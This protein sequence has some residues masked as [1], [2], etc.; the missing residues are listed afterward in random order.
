M[1]DVSSGTAASL[2]QRAIEPGIGRI[3]LPKPLASFIGRERELAQARQLLQG[4]Y[5]VTLT[6]P[7]GS[8]KTRLCIALA[9][10]VAGDYPD[11]VYFVPLAPVQD[12]GLVPSTIAQS[13]GLQDARDR[14]LMEHLVSQLR[15][16]QLLIVLD[17]FEHLLAGA[18]VVTR[19]LQ[20]TTALRI[21]VSSRSSLRVS[22]EQECPIPPLPVPDPEIRPT[23]A[24]LADCES[25]RLFAERAAAA[26]PGFTV[27]DENASAIAQ[28]TRR[29]DGLPLA[30]E[31]AA[32]RVKLLPPEA[33][34]PRLEHSL[35]LLTGGRRD[36]PDRQQTLRRTIAWSH[37]LLT[38]GARR[39]LATC[40]VFAGGPTLEVIETVCGAAVDI[41]LPVLDGLQELAD[42]SLLRQVRGPGSS[43]ARYA[44]LETIREYAAERLEAMPEADRVRGAHAAAFLALVDTGGRPHA[45]LAKKEWLER[46][47]AEH[48]NIRAA[49]GWYRWHDPP[50]AL[51]L[52]ASMAAFW[53]LRGHHTE[54]RQRLGELLGLVPD[55]SL[56]RVSALN[57]AAWLAIDQGDYARAKEMLAESI[58]LSHAL[59]DT[60]GEGI[61]T[62]YLGRCTMSSGRMRALLARRRVGRQR[63]GQ[64]VVDAR[65]HRRA[66]AVQLETRPV[67]QPQVL[68]RGRW[69]SE[70]GQDALGVAKP[71][72]EV[73]MGVAGVEQLQPAQ[74][75][76]VGPARRIGRRTSH[77]QRHVV[78][79]DRV[80]QHARH[81][82]CH[83]RDVQG[84]TDLNGRAVPRA[85]PWGR[86]RARPLAAGAVEGGRTAGW[87][88]H[89][90][91]TRHWLRHGG[92]ARGAALRRE[93]AVLLPRGPV[94]PPGGGHGAAGGPGVP[95]GAQLRPGVARLGAAA[96]L[97]QDRRGD[98]EGVG[99]HQHAA[100]AE[101]SGGGRQPDHH[102]GLL[103]VGE[104]GRAR[105]EP[106]DVTAR[107]RVG[108]DAD[109]GV[110]HQP[111]AAH[112]PAVGVLLTHRPP[113]PP[114]SRVPSPGYA[115][116]QPLTRV[117]IV[118]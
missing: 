69:R 93:P 70:T 106:P 83:H 33:I 87:S 49:L 110:G 37:D 79:A 23:A 50:A 54:G 2:S 62:V 84:A 90:N 114:P 68:H 107:H 32:A 44:M 59:G 22:G 12:P 63:V 9:A 57:G 29:L 99:G 10:A 4:S 74:I 71:A 27:S 18:P 96:R 31:L 88:H 115:F 28:I 38:E 48:N 16:R 105:D 82:C 58:G 101:R 108:D 66:L 60:V 41:G 1:P 30:I 72:A 8:V 7:G 89:A 24:S 80:R 42:H 118:I 111:V 100:H 39:L 85:H 26:V 11:G 91:A 103:G 98:P 65:H 116:P 75:P 86:H 67:E 73:V 113:C 94:L 51:R 55:P 81:R 97:P 117:T 102:A 46:V 21:L 61:A 104:H 47:D 45:G 14:P 35:G 36:L 34:L 95:A 19:L 56:A 53:S 109:R 43:Q 15:E 20:E 76:R 92:R 77:V 17:N 6:G 3:S 40:S 25:V 52:A 64:N 78:A 13:I 5:L 112:P